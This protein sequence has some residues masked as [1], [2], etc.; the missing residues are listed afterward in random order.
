MA[1][2]SALI[3]M[4]GGVDSSAAAQLMLEAGYRCE[5]CTMKLYRNGKGE[6]CRAKSCCSLRDMDDAA[7]VAALLEIPFSVVDLTGTFREK[8]VDKFVRVYEEGGT[9]NPCIDCNRYLK[10]DALLRLAEE[11]GL[12]CMVTGHYARIERSGDKFLLKKGL[13]EAKD[14]SYV[15]YMLTQAQLAR[16]R[17][18]LGDKTKEEIRALAGDMG[19]PNA[20][21]PDSQ[22]ICFVPD[23]DYAAFLERYRGKPYQEGDFVDETGRILGRHGG[24]VRYTLGQRRGLGL[25]MGE[26]AYV[27]G[28]DMEKNTVT[29]GPETALYIKTVW[30]GDMNWVAGEVPGGPIRVKAKTRYRQREEPAW[31]YPVEGGVRLEFDAPQRAVTPGQAAVLY[32]GDTVLGGGTVLP[33]EKP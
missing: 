28:K 25:P 10:F 23:G 24:A 33:P 6:L 16:I 29:V 7:K 32:D 1:E 27:C 26:R 31:A 30:A 3:A 21:K 5:G 15:L 4:S 8:V 17:F 13:D 12:S 22:D 11:K 19:F 20:Q 9:P 18:P 2:K 14:Q